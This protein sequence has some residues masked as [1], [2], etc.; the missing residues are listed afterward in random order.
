MTVRIS[1]LTR[2]QRRRCCA[3]GSRSIL[4]TVNT[5]K[6]QRPSAFGSR[7]RVTPHREVAVARRMPFCGAMS[8][9]HTLDT[10]VSVTRDSDYR[11][12]VR[13]HHGRVP[14]LFT[15]EPPPLGAGE[16]PASQELLAAA[17]GTCLCSSLLFCMQKARLE[18]RDLAADVVV[19][20][21]RNEQG[22]L[23]VEAG[24]RRADPHRDGRD[25]REDGALRRA[26]RILL[27]GRRKRATGIPGPRRPGAPRDRPVVRDRG[28]GPARTSSGPRGVASA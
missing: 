7:V 4:R 24:R 16:G 22:R 25:A 15:D 2:W 28:V 8:Q 23:R 11:F 5:A 12:R 9:D 3:E 21:A 27:F 13:F 18:P 14:D 1:R 17:I 6:G 19:S 26:L 20:T 10:R